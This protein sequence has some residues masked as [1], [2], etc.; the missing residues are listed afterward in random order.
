MSSEKT[1]GEWL[2]LCLCVDCKR[3]RYQGDDARGGERRRQ[4][5]RPLQQR[6]SHTSLLRGIWSESSFQDHK[7]E[8][9][10]EV[11]R[12]QS[13]G[14]MVLNKRVMGLLAVTRSFGDHSIKEFVIADPYVQSLSLTPDC[15]F[16]VMGCDGVF[17]V[18]SDSE[19]CAIVLDCLQ[20]VR[21]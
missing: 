19:V 20:A 14:G 5:H 9:R 12:I 4:S 21:S 8:D 18:L 17:D 6:L 7:A 13:A 10:G 15:E 16:L 1:D 11:Q 2:H 3:S